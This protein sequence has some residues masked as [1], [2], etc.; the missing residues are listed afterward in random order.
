M[1][2][3]PSK[4]RSVASDKSVNLVLCVLVSKCSQKIQEKY[5]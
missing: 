4:I 2:Q 1:T 3:E 5:Q